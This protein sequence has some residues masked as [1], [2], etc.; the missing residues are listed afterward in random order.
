MKSMIS[1]VSLIWLW[2]H[3]PTFRASSLL[4]SGSLSVN[5]LKPI[6]KGH[7]QDSGAL[8]PTCVLGASCVWHWDYGG[9]KSLP[10]SQVL[11]QECRQGSGEGGVCVRVG[12]CVHA[13][14]HMCMYVRV[15]VWWHAYYSTQTICFLSTVITIM[16]NSSGNWFS[17][18]N[19]K[20][21]RRRVC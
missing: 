11:H 7:Y 18:R 12:A 17:H 21:V 10:I 9:V 1:A 4:N 6:Y 19:A 15:C 14:T 16:S 20:F 3:V 5:I 8:D 2:L 13:Y